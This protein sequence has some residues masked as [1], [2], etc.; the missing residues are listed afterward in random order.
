MTLNN[1]KFKFPD[2]YKL[3]FLKICT[4]ILF[5]HLL[6]LTERHHNKPKIYFTFLNFTHVYFI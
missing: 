4:N 2:L 1:D 3:F 6:N 5:S